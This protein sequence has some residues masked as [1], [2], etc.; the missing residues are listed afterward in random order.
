MFQISRDKSFI[1][2]CNIRTPI[3]SDEEVVG[4]G[5]F[6][7]KDEKAFL[8]TASH[9]ADDTNC[10]TYIVLCDSSNNPTTVAL[11]KLNPDLFWIKHSIEDI[12]ALEIDIANNLDILDHRCFPF[13]QIEFDISKFSRDDELTCVGFPNGLGAL[14]KY[15]PFTFRSYLSAAEVSFERFDNHVKAVFACLE[16]PSVGGYSGG[17]IFDLGVVSVGNIKTSKGS[18]RLLGIM[19]GTIFDETGGKIAVFSPALYLR[20][21]I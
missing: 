13:R 9:V 20:D 11:K 12:A 10:K 2:V 6:I 19:H 18:T 16:N 1:V 14:G 7:S 15:C 4:T 8:V 3:S 21:I 5:I 17:P